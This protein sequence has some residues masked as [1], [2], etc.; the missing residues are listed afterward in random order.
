MRNPLVTKL[1]GDLAKAEAA[2]QE[3]L[4]RYTDEDRRVKEEREQIAFLK[5][6]LA[7]ADEE[8][9][10]RKTTGLNP[11][12]EKLKGQLSTAESKLFS[13]IS[14][15]KIVRKQISDI[16][17]TL[18]VLR[19]KKVEIDGLSRV[20]D[21]RENTFMLYGKKLEQ[22]RIAT[23][24]GKEQLANVALISPPHASNKTDIKKRGRIVLMGAFVGLVLGMALAFGFEFFNNS[25]RTRQDVEYYLG[26]PVLA[27]IPDLKGR[28]ALED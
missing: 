2:L 25:L 11:L 22:A 18:A 5:Q 1:E 15:K 4:H 8:I 24:L 17:A 20:V 21:L 23:G 10:A 13:L 26:L 12:R 16:S 19:G 28:P 9:P 14:Q 7:S 27:A 6:Q 3:L